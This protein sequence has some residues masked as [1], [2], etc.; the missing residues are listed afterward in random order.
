[1]I[2]K[3]IRLRAE[4]KGNKRK[5][6]VQYHLHKTGGLTIQAAFLSNFEDNAFEI[7]TPQ[8]MSAFET[9]IKDGSFAANGTYFFYG[10]R[11]HLVKD[12]IEALMPTYAFAMVR[13]PLSLFQSNFSFIRNR[14]ALADLNELDFF[15][16]YPTN[17]IITF[18]KCG[19]VDDALKLFLD[20]LVY[21]GV[22][23]KLDECFSILK[24]MFNLKEKEYGS[25]NITKSTE[26]HHISPQLSETFIKKNIEDYIVYETILS[27]HEVLYREFVLQLTNKFSHFSRDESSYHKPTVAN[28]DLEN[29][30]NKFSVLLTAKDLFSIDQEMSIA[31]FDKA[32]SMDWNLFFQAFAFLK[33]A[34]STISEQWRQ[35]KID[36]LTSIGSDSARS[37]IIRINH[38]LAK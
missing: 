25:S 19:S 30:D 6:I 36:Y 12:K 7:S 27:Y 33:E 34:N 8:E 26:Y 11:V 28:Y 2:D 14:Q 3:Y 31:F 38:E 17:K 5:A 1:M 23:E 32:F 37:F 13:K 9:K 15:A 22:M 21:V 10:H 18:F 35:S 29:N 20:D 24:Y 4:I 16:D